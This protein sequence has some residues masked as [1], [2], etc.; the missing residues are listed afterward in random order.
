[1]FDRLHCGSNRSKIAVWNAACLF[2]SSNGLL[3]LFYWQINIG[4]L[5]TRATVIA[6]EQR[7]EGE[8]DIEK[9]YIN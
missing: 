4:L 9:S 8:F 7:R 5:T 1:M 2:R 3:T 6:S